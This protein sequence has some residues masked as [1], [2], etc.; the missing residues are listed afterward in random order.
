MCWERLSCRYFDFTIIGSFPFV[1]LSADWYWEFLLGDW[2]VFP[3]E[4]VMDDWRIG[5]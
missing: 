4:G 2:F 5:V 3:F 1:V